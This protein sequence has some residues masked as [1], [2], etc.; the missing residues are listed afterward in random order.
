M[1]TGLTAPSRKKSTALP[2]GSTTPCAS[3]ASPYDRSADPDSASNRPSRSLTRALAASAI[4]LLSAGCIH[5]DTTL[6]YQQDQFSERTSIAAAASSLPPLDCQAIA[7]LAL[8]RMPQL[9]P[10]H[11]AAQPGCHVS[12]PPHPTA[13]PALA[14]AAVPAGDGL[15]HVS[16]RLDFRNFHLRGGAASALQALAATG[17]PLCAY[18]S[19]RRPTPDALDALAACRATAASLT[20]HDPTHLARTEAALT[21]LAGRTTITIT[22]SGDVL[23][24]G[25]AFQP[26]TPHPVRHAWSGTAI[27]LLDATARGTLYWIVPTLPPEPR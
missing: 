4:A 14:W 18:L 27:E 26:V 2:P 9:T 22:L 5:V 10:P 17:N 7:A 6:H 13:A 19:L 21:E 20:A 11:G 8:A 3:S 16:P 25:P 23:Q 15:L 1:T 12:F 24:A